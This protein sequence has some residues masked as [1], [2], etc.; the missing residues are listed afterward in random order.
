MDRLRF[1]SIAPMR[2]PLEIGLLNNMPDAALHATE[3]QFSHLLKAAAGRHT[4]RL[5]FYSLPEAPRGEHTRTYMDTLYEDPDRMFE[6]GLDGLI[7]TGNEPKAADLSEEP[8]WRRLTEVIDW[9][10]TGVHGSYWS[11]LGAH[12]AVQHLDG[13]RR[14]RLPSKCSGVF[15][16]ERVGEDLM[17]S[18]LRA[19]LLTPHS[20]LNGL[21]E[22]ELT[23][24]GYKILTRSPEAGVDLF[25]RRAPSLMVFCQGHPEYDADTLLREY[26]RDAGRYLC[27]K[28]NDQPEL[29]ANYLSLRTRDALAAAARRERDP[30]VIARYNA[31]AAMAKPRKA[32]RSSAIGLFR[33]WLGQIAAGKA[34]AA[35]RWRKA[36]TP[37]LDAAPR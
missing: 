13:I 34:A 27:G 6:A 16:S 20:R 35:R 2:R 10:R 32:W 12:A 11:C 7:V 22:A 30:A 15:E 29:P 5:R 26:C 23:E 18:R 24:H 21:S 33:N 14:V 9:A 4:V 36:E 31:I 8:Y 25:V 28:C 1:A 19:P 17:L 37:V 3:Q